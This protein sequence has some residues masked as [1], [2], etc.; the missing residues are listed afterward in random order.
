MN[1]LIV[2]LKNNIF[3]R[4]KIFIEDMGC[5]VPFG[6]KIYKSEVKDIMGYQDFEESIGGDIL[7]D[8]MKKNILE[9][10]S[11]AIIDIAGIAYDV[12]LNLENKNGLK[13][14]R[15]ALCLIYT[16]D[17]QHWVAEYYPYT[18]IDNECVWHRID[19]N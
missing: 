18:L 10:F 1:D 9:E 5:F 11:K 2:E 14:D 4:A 15:D 8:L 7:I 6:V 12:T 19:I 16:D 17:G 13:E 3:S